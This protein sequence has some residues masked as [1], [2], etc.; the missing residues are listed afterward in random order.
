MQFETGTTYYTRSVCDHN[1]IFEM[2]VLSRT[3]KTIKINDLHDKSSI[4]TLRIFDYEGV[5]QV[6]PLGSYSMSPI[7]GADG[8]TVLKPEWE[9]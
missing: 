4:K 3:A 7:I 1:C 5:E 9:L 8:T 2:T 6:S